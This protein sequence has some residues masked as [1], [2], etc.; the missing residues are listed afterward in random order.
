MR[1]RSAAVDRDVRKIWL[2]WRAGR[3]GELQWK[4]RDKRGII[5]LFH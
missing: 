4:Q 2:S 1:R 3:E 5:S